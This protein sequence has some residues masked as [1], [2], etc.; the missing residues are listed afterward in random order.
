MIRP[1]RAQLEALACPCCSTVTAFCPTCGAP[2]SGELPEPRPVFPLSYASTCDNCGTHLEVI[3]V[4]WLKRPASLSDPLP[5]L[6]RAWSLP[7]ARR[8]RPAA[9][10]VAAPPAPAPAPRPKPCPH[11]SARYRIAS[12]S[13]WGLLP[14]GL[15]PSSIAAAYT[16]ATGCTPPRDPARKQSRAYSWQELAAALAELG[17]P[18]PPDP[19]PAIWAA[20]LACLQLPSTRM[21]F[22]QQTR[23]LQLDE[24]RAVV[25]AAPHWLE[26]VEARR[27][28]LEQSLADAT[29]CHRVV[30]LLPLVQE[31]GR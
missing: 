8:P 6:E 17:Y 18:P 25:G 5:T 23:L 31:L 27:D 29:G 12:W 9:A 24:G 2:W 19:L 14:A 7:P 3:A 26:M 11:G 28:L 22:S 1:L 21:L 13:A 16:R 15:T 20:A 10:V 4:D 30:A